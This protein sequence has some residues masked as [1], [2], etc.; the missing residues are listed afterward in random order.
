MHSLEGHE[1]ANGS[2]TRKRS[3]NCETSETGLSDGSVDD[4][5]LTKLV[6][7]AT[8][9]LVGTVVCVDREACQKSRFSILENRMSR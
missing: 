1:L 7:K 4:S 8:R 9:D 2:E 6:E 3:T 5:A